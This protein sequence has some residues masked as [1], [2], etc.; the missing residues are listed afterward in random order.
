MKRILI[1]EDDREILDIF[2]IIF[3][4][5]GYQIVGLLNDNELYEYLASFNPHLI[6]LDI[7]LA[8]VDGLTL[9]RQMRSDSLYSHIPIVLTTA[10]IIDPEN[11]TG[12]CEGFISKPF[13]I[14]DVLELARSIIGK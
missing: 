11:L 6:I 8:G 12:C 2:K 3:C 5:E 13:D 9:A 10:G 1:L 4:D 14:E 7:Q